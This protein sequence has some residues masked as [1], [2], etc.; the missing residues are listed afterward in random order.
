MHTINIGTTRFHH[1]GDFSGDVT[2]VCGNIADAGEQFEVPFED[3]EAF[4]VLKR[5]HQLTT[6]LEGLDV[7][8]PSDRNLIEELHSQCGL[9][10]LEK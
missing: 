2:I 7:R 4:V 5:F 6:F 8:K 10:D 1:N 3:L 9:V